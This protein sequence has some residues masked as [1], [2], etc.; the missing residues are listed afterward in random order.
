MTP[1]E[2]E[3]IPLQSH[4]SLLLFLARKSSSSWAVTTEHAYQRQWQEDIRCPNLG[5]EGRTDRRSDINRR[6]SV[7]TDAIWANESKITVGNVLAQNVL[8][9]EDVLGGI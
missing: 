3:E 7:R 1:C 4:A 9:E 5:P 2:S 8:Y 6:R